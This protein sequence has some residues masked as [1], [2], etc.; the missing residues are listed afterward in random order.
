M[1]E[2]DSIN[3]NWKY[4]FLYSSEMELKA[5]HYSNEN[6]CQIDGDFKTWKKKT[7]LKDLNKFIYFTLF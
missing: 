5:Y 6:Q 2:N 1:V 7:F 3:K 4:S